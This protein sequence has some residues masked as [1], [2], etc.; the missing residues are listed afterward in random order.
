LETEQEKQKR[1]EATPAE[2][3]AVLEEQRGA[4][5][6]KRIGLERKIREVEARAQ[7]KSWGES[8]EGQERKRP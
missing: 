7:G 4:L 5:V 3:I 2:K 8:R 6:A 1:V